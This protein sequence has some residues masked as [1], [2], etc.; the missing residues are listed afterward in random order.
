MRN[1]A[2]ANYHRNFAY[3]NAN[4][5]AVLA[6]AARCQYTSLSDK[7]AYKEDL[8]YF[9]IV[10]SIQFCLWLFTAWLSLPRHFRLPRDSL[11]GSYPS[12][13]V[14]FGGSYA[15][16]DP[17]SPGIA[18]VVLGIAQWTRSYIAMNTSYEPNYAY[19]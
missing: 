15:F 8:S 7:V 9:V 3:A 19:L 10:R 11:A 2:T 14:W 17:R 18:F 12:L 16:L 6:C 1:V 4:V 5:N 13:G